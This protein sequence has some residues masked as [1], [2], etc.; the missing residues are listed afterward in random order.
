LPPETLLGETAGADGRWLCSV[1]A[2]HTMVLWFRPFSGSDSA[3]FFPT[4]APGGCVLRPPSGINKL[5]F[6]APHRPT[7]CPKPHCQAGGRVPRGT[8]RSA[9][10]RCA[11]RPPCTL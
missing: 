11:V 9:P 4:T 10:A 3:Q 2:L 5:N 1:V 6:N 8:R 7:G